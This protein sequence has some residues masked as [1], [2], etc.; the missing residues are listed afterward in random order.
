MK[1]GIKR[2]AALVLAA[3]VVLSL[4]ATALAAGTSV[5]FYGKK[6]GFGWETGREYTA[7]DLF[8]GFKNVL[9]GDRLSQTI[10]ITNKAR[11]CNYIKLY[12]RLRAHDGEKNPMEAESG[13]SVVSM[14]DFLSQLTMRVYR[15]DRLIYEN[16]PDRADEL[17]ENVLLGTLYREKSAKLRVELD[18]PEDL[19]NQYANRLGEVDWVLHADAIQEDT[20]AQTGQR[21]WPVAV[22]GGLGVLCV[23][24]GIFLRRRKT[25]G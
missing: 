16:S 4:S 23:A 24:V 3:A 6:K 13:E 21:N 17:R 14:E 11:D 12:L 9:P 20:L 1:R 18:I 10:T 5:T 7:T 25:H 19:D 2:L 22:L 15:G 8:S